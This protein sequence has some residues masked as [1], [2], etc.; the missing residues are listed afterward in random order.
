VRCSNNPPAAQSRRPK[1]LTQDPGLRQGKA[2]IDWTAGYPTAPSYQCA[3][4][5]VRQFSLVNR[6]ILV[7]LQARSGLSFNYWEKSCLRTG[8]IL[9]SPW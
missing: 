8:R 9:R 4:K 5:Q 2:A 1:F 3:F 6:H 7:K